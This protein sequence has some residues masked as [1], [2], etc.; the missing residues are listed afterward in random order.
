MKATPP[1][2]GIGAND[3]SE[4]TRLWRDP[5]WQPA[6]A[7]FGANEAWIL[8]QQMEVTAVA[9]PTHYEA[10]RAEWMLRQ[11]QE[12]GLEAHIDAVGNAVGE[13][14]GTDGDAPLLAL[15]AHMDTAFAPG[16][17]VHPERRGGRI[18][19]PGISDNGTGLA[20]L[21]AVARALRDLG[22]RTR[23]PL[24]FVAN[25]GEEGEG[26]LKGMRHLFHADNPLARRI[27]RT[28]VLD[29]PGTEHITCAAL[30]SR[31]LRLVF[32]G[33]GGHSWSDLGRASAVH[34][35]MRTGAALLAQVQPEPDRLGCNLGWVQGGTAVNAI[36]AEA[37]IKLDLRADEPAKLETL[38]QA[39]R[40]ALAVGLE[41]ENAA[42]RSGKVTA[43]IELLGARPGGALPAESRLLQDVRRV[44]GLLGIA[45][46]IQRASTDANIPL[47]QGREALRLGAGG[48]GGGVHTLQEWFD[49][50][51][52]ALALQRVLLLVLLS[53][54]TA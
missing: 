3:G 42:A 43:Q 19:A 53:A 31:R 38:E 9:A 11:W 30:P 44:D 15:T 25:V 51:G 39:V 16:T 8:Q 20:A 14:R 32:E 45:S 27:G 23:A 6:F 12:L 50:T 10:L 34:A 47:S 26:D 21:L 13:R 49:P 18:W 28:V 5:A 29:G 37:Q 22:I 48:Q 17:P 1:Y 52:R 7:W 24:L 54:G 40:R 46:E 2:N 4:A 33:P 35:V 41:Q 36:A